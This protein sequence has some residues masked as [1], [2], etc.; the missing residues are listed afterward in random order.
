MIFDC[1]ECG[2]NLTESNFFK[3][4]KKNCEN[5]SNEKPEFRIS[6]MFFTKQIVD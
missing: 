3:R 5:C 1:I 4:V 6:S 2:K